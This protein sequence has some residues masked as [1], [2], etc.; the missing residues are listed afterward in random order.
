MKKKFLALL[1][2]LAMMLTLLPVTV[3]A[4]ETTVVVTL[5][6]TNYT[7]GYLRVEAYNKEGGKVDELADGCDNLVS[8]EFPKDGYV[9]VW[10]L[11]NFQYQQMVQQ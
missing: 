5:D 10:L 2:V 9:V 11:E 3:M 7:G 1:T 8:M 4:D 6:K